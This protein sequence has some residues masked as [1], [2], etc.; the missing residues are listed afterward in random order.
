[1]QI[2][3]KSNFP[4]VE[5]KLRRL[6]QG[7]RDKALTSAVNKTLE[8]ARTQMTREITREFNVSATYV[9]DRLR[10]RRAAKARAFDISASLVGSGKNGAKRSANL[11]AFV[12]KKVTLAQARKRAK[13]GTLQQLFVKVKRGG[14]AKPVRGAF[15][16]NKGRT[17]FRREGKSRLPIEPVQTVDVPQMFT[18]SRINQAV[19]RA[20]RER[21]PRIVASEI[22]FFTQRFNG[23]RG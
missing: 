23:G 18:T 17:V 12:E 5:K 2:S 16:G 4:E 11:I 14:S 6:E 19:V 13:D 3:I 9:R 15:I 8:Q 21:F 10:V 22:R 1:M 20:I 7:V